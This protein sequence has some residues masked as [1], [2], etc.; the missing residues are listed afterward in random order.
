VR[1][2]VLYRLGLDIVTHRIMRLSYGIAAATEFR[3][4]YHPP[5]RKCT[6]I[7]GIV[8]CR[9]VMDWYAT[10]VTYFVSYSA[11]SR[12]RGLQGGLSF[13]IISKWTSRS[14]NT[15]NIDRSTTRSDY[16]HPLVELLQNTKKNRVCPFLVLLTL[17]LREH[18]G[19]TVDLRDIP[20]TGWERRSGPS[21]YYRRATYDISLTLGAGGMELQLRHDDKVIG[22]VEFNYD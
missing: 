10:K 2:A 3:E 15:L 1:G 12:A 11:D 7:D 16:G 22:A 13:L 5:A 14:P 19:L 21:G 17:E 6:G 18:C 8:R 4:G 9:D 20:A